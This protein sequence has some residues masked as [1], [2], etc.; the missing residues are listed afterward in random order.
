MLPSSRGLILRV[1]HIVHLNFLRRGTFRPSSAYISVRGRFLVVSAVLCLCGRTHAL[2]AVKRPVS[3]LGSRGV[4]SHIVTVGC[5]IPGSHPR[6]FTRCRESVSTFCRR[7]LRGGTWK[8]AAVVSVRCL[9]LDDVGNPLVILRNMRSTFCSRV[10]RFIMSNA[11]HGVKHVMRVC[12]SGTMVR[13][14]RN[15]RGVSLGGARAGLAKRPVRVT[16]SPS[17]LNHAFGNVNRPVSSLKP[18]ISALGESMGK[19]PLGPIHERCPEGCV[20]AKVSTVSKL[21]ALVQKRG[22]PVFSKG[23]L[24]RSRLTTRVMGRTSLKDSSSRGFTVMFTTVKMGRSITS[25]FHGAFR[26]DNITSRITVFLGLTGSPIMRHLVAPGITLATTRCLTFRRGVRVLIVLASVASF[27]RTVHRI[28]SSGKR[29]PDHGKFPKC[30]C[31]RLT[32]VCRHTN[33]M[34]NMGKSMARLPVLAVPGSS[35][36][37]PVPSLAKCVAR[38]RVMLS[39]PLRKR[40]VCPPVGVLPSLSH[41]VGSN[42]KRNFAHRSRRSLTGRL[43][44]TCT[45]IKST[46]GLTSIVNRSRL[47]PLSGGCLRFKVSFRRRCVNRNIG[48]GHAV[49]RALSLK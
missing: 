42:V 31:D 39:H 29:V 14:F 41:L 3:M 10:M 26:R 22:L 32:A 46:E 21:A 28:S 1:T 18:L 27:T 2:I 13:I 40:S 44:S 25:F 36:A 45:G 5:S 4:F 12:R 15:S 33:V 30:L 49:R 23:K 24:P 9:N 37:R 8:K 34:R 35:V 7:M 19:L 17:V 43:F 16:L 38:K 47:S 20:H 6:V 11:R 48:R